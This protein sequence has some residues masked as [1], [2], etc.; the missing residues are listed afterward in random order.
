MSKI[1]Q[2]IQE[3]LIEAATKV[4]ANAYAPYSN[5]RVGAALLLEDGSIEVGCNVENA[6]YGLSICA[7]RVAVTSMIA[8]GKSK[9]LAV[10]VVSSPQ[11]PAAPCGACRQFLS[12]FNG[13]MP[14][15]M[16]SNGGAVKTMSLAE[17][18]PLQFSGA[19]LG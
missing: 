18:L 11:D 17:L 7:E 4:Q 12:E 14:V 1:T 5:F 16:A 2:Q 6:S 15:I 19:S 13:E 3:K 8:K 9:I 10:A